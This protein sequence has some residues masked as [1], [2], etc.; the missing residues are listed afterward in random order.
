MIQHAQ[1]PLYDR[2]TTL[3]THTRHSESHTFTQD[4]LDTQDFDTQQRN[5]S[6]LC[7][8]NLHNSSKF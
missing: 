3:Q 5:D 6:S 2:H 1:T 7:P 8:D 4:T